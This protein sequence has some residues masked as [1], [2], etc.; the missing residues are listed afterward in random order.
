MVAEEGFSPGPGCWVP[1]VG[2]AVPTPS[3][4][5]VDIILNMAQQ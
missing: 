4:L 3:C 2:R 1:L 5:E